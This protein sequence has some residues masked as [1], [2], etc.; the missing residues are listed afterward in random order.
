MLNV[1]TQKTLPTQSFTEDKEVK[2]KYNIEKIIIMV[3]HRML[4][5]LNIKRRGFYAIP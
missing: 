2:S 1:V 5:L 3:V 4:W